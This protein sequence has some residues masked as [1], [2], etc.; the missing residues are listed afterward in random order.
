VIVGFCL[1]AAGMIGATRAGNAIAERIS[2]PAMQHF[3]LPAHQIRHYC[4]RRRGTGISSMA[5]AER[6]HFNLG[7]Q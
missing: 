6:A 2:D 3:L 1:G 7:A 4:D 5:G